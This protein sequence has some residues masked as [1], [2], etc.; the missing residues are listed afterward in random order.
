MGHLGAVQGWFAPAAP[1]AA[2]RRRSR[3]CATSTSSTRSSGCRLVLGLAWRRGR[4]RRARRRDAR[5]GARAGPRP[6]SPGRWSGDRRLRGPRRRDCRPP[7]GRITPAGGVRGRARTTGAT[8]RTGWPRS[9]T[10]GWR[11]SSR[12]PCFGT[13]VWGSPAD[14][15][16][17]AL[18]ATPWAVRN[19]VPL[20]PA[21][22]IRMLDAIEE[23]FAQGHGSTGARRLPA[24]QRR[25]PPRRAQ[26]PRRAATTTPTRCWSTRPSTS[27]PGIEL[28]ADVR[29]GARRRRAHRGRARP[30]HHQRWLA[31]RRTPRSRSTRSTSRRPPG[32]PRT[33]R[34]SWSAAPRTCST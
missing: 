16:F 15:P 20:T 26:R 25:Q 28:A 21:G 1:G 4:A 8:P 22:N 24:P 13:Y 6:T 9:R 29:P 19:A 27:R 10:T 14:E 5:D 17:Q 33:R 11:C 34:P 30:R 2:R 12:A 7:P 31:E 23:R 18:A 32:R 3:R